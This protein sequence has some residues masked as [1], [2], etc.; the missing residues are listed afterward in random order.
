[1]Y[2][3]CQAKNGRQRAERGNHKQSSRDISEDIMLVGWE[4]TTSVDWTF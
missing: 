1:M 3:Q 4:R 2:E